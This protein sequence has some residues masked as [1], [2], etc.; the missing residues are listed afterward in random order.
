MNE[1]RIDAT[2]GP[3][4]VEEM[5]RLAFSS[6]DYAR[7]VCEN[8]DVSNFPRQMGA[9]KAMLKV[10]T[11]TYRKT[12]KLATFGSVEMAFP[13]NED[14]ANKIREI[15]ALPI[16]DYQIMV[17]QLETFIRRQ[18]FIATQNEVAEM[19]NSGKMEESMVLLEK[20]MQTI[21]T[22]SLEGSSG[23]FLRV[24]RD[25]YANINK[26]QKRSED[27]TY[28]L[29]IPTGITSIDHLTGG[30]IP[31]QD[32]VLWIMR[33]G[34]GKSTVLKY[35]AWYN[36]YVIHNHCLH[37]QLEGG[38]NECV[39]KFDQMVADITYAEMLKGVMSDNKKSKLRK[40]ISRAGLMDSDVDVYASEEMVDTT[41]ADLVETI[42]AYFREHGYYPDLVTLDSLD[43]LI[44]GES[45]KLDFDPAYIK[46]K[47]QRCAQKLKDIAKKY[48]CVVVTATQT[49]EVPFEI[50]NDPTKVITRSNTEGDRTLVKPFSFVFTGNITLEESRQ[51]LCRIYFDKLRNY[52]NNGIIAKIPTDYDHGFFYDTKRA[53]EVESIFEASETF[54]ESEKVSRRR[55]RKAD[56]E[57][58][59]PEVRVD[60]SKAAPAAQDNEVV[61]KPQRT[62][63]KK[64]Q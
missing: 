37:V 41:V 39:I 50:W 13:D 26:A 59:K 20:R 40:V 6:L 19:Y 1:R 33:S 51:Q 17:D 11:D 60:I 44:T 31:R 21:N 15:K 8:L 49:G 45:K 53:H 22:F 55:S 58:E 25:F 62:A 32:T 48:D 56:E 14:V 34:V 27:E 28:Q 2:L 29:L 18:T 43:L 38:L 10:L 16:P 36:T 9:C 54:A 3:N 35:F 57:K 63:I 5:L 24:Y 61:V 64:R 4:F 47:L 12:G 7:L 42:E 23:R 46:Y 30:G 52:K